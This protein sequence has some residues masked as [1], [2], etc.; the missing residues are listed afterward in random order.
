MIKRILTKIM[1]WKQDSEDLEVYK[2]MVRRYELLLKRIA[3]TA[4][5]NDYNMPVLKFRKIKE[6]AET[7]I[8]KDTY[9]NGQDFWEGFLKN[10]L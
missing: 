1:K 4:G 3:H 7:D 6:L 9:D 2:E 8:S 10:N 5:D